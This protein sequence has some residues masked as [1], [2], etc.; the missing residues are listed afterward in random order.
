MNLLDPQT[1][2]LAAL[3]GAFVLLAVAIL[4]GGTALTRAADQIAEATG[5]SAAL[6]GALLLGAT[7][8]LPGTI[9]SVTTAWGGHAELAVANAIGGITAQTAFLT[10]ADLVYRRGNLEYAAASIATLMQSMLLVALLSLALVAMSLPTVTLFAV[11]PASPILIAVYIGGLKLVDQ[12][13]REPMWRPTPV[14]TERRPEGHEPATRSPWLRFALLAVATG[15]AGFALARV[16]VALAAAT[17]LSE[18]AVGAAFTAVV[19]SLP[20][21][22]TAVAAVRRGALQLAVGG[23]IGGNAYDVLFLSLS[24][25]AYREGSL[26]HAFTTDHVLLIALSILMTAVVAL[27]M[28]KRDRFGPAQIGFE[29]VLVLVLYLASLARLFADGG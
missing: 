12:A 6:M 24:D 4:A 3:V 7:T 28:L 29:S 19:T 27:G 2:P 14:V 11:H 21:L 16:A 5:L 23:I 1:W 25:V 26:Y 13:E 20:E 22:V 17:G 10:I 8:S 18:S 15:C 9:V